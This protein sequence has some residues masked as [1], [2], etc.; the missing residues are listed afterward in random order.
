MPVRLRKGPGNPNDKARRSTNSKGNGKAPVAKT[1]KTDK[2]QT[3]EEPVVI[4]V[5]RTVRRKPNGQDA[6]E[7]SGVDQIGSKQGAL[8]ETPGT[9]D[10]DLDTI[11]IRPFVTEP[12][13]VTYDYGVSR[14]LNFQTVHIGVKVTLPCYVEEVD[15]ALEEAKQICIRRLKSEQKTV[16][17][18]LDKLVEMRTHGE[19]KLAQQGLG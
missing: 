1:S 4:R 10:V 2:K 18:V 14:S 6:D 3:I 19:Q 15:E 13:K 12:A 16:T 5:Q 7:K 8:N 17:A 9:T 11:E